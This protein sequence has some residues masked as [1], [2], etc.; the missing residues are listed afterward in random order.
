MKD[1][2]AE[3]YKAHERLLAQ[4]LDDPQNLANADTLNED[5]LKDLAMAQMMACVFWDTYKPDTTRYKV[6]GVELEIVANVPGLKRPLKGILDLVLYDVVKNALWIVDFKS[7]GGDPELYAAIASYNPQSRVYRLLVEAAL[8]NQ[9]LSFVAEDGAEMIGP[10]TTV[11]GICF[12]VMQ[13]P[14]IRWKKKTQSLQ[15]YI[16]EGK[17]WYEG[18]HPTSKGGGPAAMPAPS[19]VP[20]TE[21]LFDPEFLV[22]LKLIEGYATGKTRFTRF[23]RTMSV[24]NCMGPFGKSPCKYLPLCSTSK[25][26]WKTTIERMFTKRKDYVPD[27]EG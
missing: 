6:V 9:Q 12:M 19:F 14:S 17:L 23:P 11:A 22:Q 24:Y 7:V 27:G 2:L 18:T 16:D 5:L 1:A 15:E 21:E 20:F 25:K 8:R 3:G 13:R 26:N 4:L 10:D